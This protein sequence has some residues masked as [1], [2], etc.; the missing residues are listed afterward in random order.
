MSFMK[1]IPPSCT[2]TNLKTFQCSV[3]G[4]QHEHGKRR[5]LGGPVP[6]VAAVHKNGCFAALDPVRYASGSGQNDL[7]GMEG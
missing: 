3:V 2:Q 5:Q 6:S 7:Q 1:K 4:V